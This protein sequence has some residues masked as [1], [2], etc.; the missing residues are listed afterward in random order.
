[1]IDISQI[2]ITHPFFCFKKEMS[3]ICR[4]L[5]QEIPLS[6]FTYEQYHQEGS[7]IFLSYKPEMDYEILKAKCLP[8][9]EDL[10]LNKDHTI[11]LT[12]GMSIIPS[13]PRET[14]MKKNIDIAAN[15]DINHS[16]V[17]IFNHKRYVEMFFFGLE[18]SIQNY[19]NTFASNMMIFEKFC[20][21][22]RHEAF[23]FIQTLHGDRVVYQS[24]TGDYP[25]YEEL[26]SFW[27]Y[28]RFLNNLNI[29][30]Y[31]FKGS[32]GKCKLS[33]RQFECLLLVS[34]NKTAKQIAKL[35][36]LSPRTVEVFLNQ[37]KDKLGCETKDELQDTAQSQF[38]VNFFNNDF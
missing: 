22:F 37:L 17:L 20:I 15:F 9:I 3:R 31:F 26:A 5:F 13:S 16:M 19:M 11:I 30:K 25:P 2:N 29:E 33:P 12:K 36:N 10:T 35:L 8:T 18:K 28:R 23:D 38:M 32:H 34:K 24:N 14:I 1:M 6:Y 4:P 7:C 27:N 21:Y